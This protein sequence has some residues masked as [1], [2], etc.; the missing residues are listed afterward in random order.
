MSFLFPNSTGVFNNNTGPIT[1][2][3][4]GSAVYEAYSPTITFG[5]SAIP[6]VQSGDLLMMFFSNDTSTDHSATGWTEA[7][8]LN[9]FE[10]TS[11]MGCLYKTATSSDVSVTTTQ[12]ASTGGTEAAIMVALRGLSYARSGT[13]TV[14]T[15][16]N[17]PSQ[18]CA[19]D[20]WALIGL[21]Y[22]DDNTKASVTPPA[23][24][25]EVNHAFNYVSAALS[26]GTYLAVKSGL[27]ASSEDP[28]AFS[29]GTA[30]LGSST[31]ILTPT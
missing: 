31:V 6:G 1:L 27:T 21:H 24:Y 18:T 22:Q 29:G 16:W 25:T 10:S 23:G 19:T 2:G 5:A 17:P 20:D 30:I 8:Q 7:F 15:K 13:Q 26:S 4:V 12:N 28:A 9:G 3:I 11:N 14:T